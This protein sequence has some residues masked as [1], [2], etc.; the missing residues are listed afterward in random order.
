MA[1]D[2]AKSSSRSPEEAALRRYY[3]DILLNVS[4][5]VHLAELLLSEGFIRSETKENVAMDKDEEHAV[6]TVLD[7][8]QLALAQSTDRDELI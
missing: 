8:V 3:S 6:R 5:P 2:T 4:R 1:D 7:A